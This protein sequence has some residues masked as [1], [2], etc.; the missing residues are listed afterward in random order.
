MSGLLTP[1]MGTIKILFLYRDS[2][3]KVDLIMGQVYEVIGNLYLTDKGSS[4][5]NSAIVEAMH[6][7]FVLDRNIRVD[8]LRIISLKTIA[9]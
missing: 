3:G 7:L 2:I 1:Y 5:S 8:V 4:M 9:F 6:E